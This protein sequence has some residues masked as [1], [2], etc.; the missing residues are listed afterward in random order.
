LYL[1]KKENRDALHQD[2]EF[3]QWVI[4]KMWRFCVVLCLASRKKQKR[5][6]KARAGD[7]AFAAL[8]KE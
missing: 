1:Q 7:G 8:E 3:H 4:P 5:G 2:S 6:I